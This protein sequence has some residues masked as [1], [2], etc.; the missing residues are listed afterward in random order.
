MKVARD[1]SELDEAARAVALGTF[2]GVHLGHRRVLDAARA[3]GAR[4]T[5]VT[6]WPHPRLAFGHRVELLTTLERRLELLEE[7]DP[8][9]LLTADEALARL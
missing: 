1:P 8:E 7:A 5:V 4:S 2:D 6:F 9:R 3:A